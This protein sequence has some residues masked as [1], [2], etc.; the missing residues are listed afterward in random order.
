MET[1]DQQLFPVETQEIK[2]N[3]LRL[4]DDLSDE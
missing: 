4:I 1:V 2:W 3:R